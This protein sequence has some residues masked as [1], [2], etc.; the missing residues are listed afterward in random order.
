MAKTS[1]GNRIGAKSSGVQT[2][3]FEQFASSRGAS[4]FEG[5]RKDRDR[6]ARAKDKEI[7]KNAEGVLADMRANAKRRET[8]RVE[9]NTL[10]QQGKIKTPSRFEEL[11]KKARGHEDNP[12]TQAA[13]RV[14]EKR[15]IKW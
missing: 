10:V 8:L 9:Y 4:L 11:I 2:M 13:R 1:G 14:L 6:Q 3:T 12:A 15:G 5:A 7:R